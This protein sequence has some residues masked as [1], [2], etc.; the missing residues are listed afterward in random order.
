MATTPSP[1][2]PPPAAASQGAASP[3]PATPGPAN[4]E[5]ASPPPTSSP[6]RAPEPANVGVLEADDNV[7]A[8]D[9][10]SALGLPTDVSDTT[11]IASFLFKYREQHGRTYHAYRS[12][13]EYNSYWLPNDERE[14][15]RLDLQHNLFLMMQDNQL[16][17]CP[18]VK[19]KE[20]K[21]VLDAG[22]GTGV[23]AMDFAD[24][25]PNVSV[26]GTDISA[27]QPEFVPP[28]LEF[29][30]DD[31]EADWNFVNKFDFIYARF[32][33]GSIKDWPRFFQQSF[34]HLQPGGY[35]EVCDILYPMACD[36]GTLPDDSALQKWVR[37]V[38][39]GTRRIGAP[40]DS[41]LHYKQQLIDA[42]FQNV[43]EVKY[44]WPLNTWPK[45]KKHKEL[46]AWSLMN[47]QD[48]LSA[49]SLM[50]FTNVL[51]WSREETELLLM[52][53]RK[54]MKNTAYHGYWPIW[55]VYGQK[56]E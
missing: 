18:H 27:I 26:V 8:D 17:T 30:V 56:P 11:S 6:A 34:E 39:E 10:D 38:L 48:A 21:R 36:D 19:G 12:R 7:P 13:G 14:N 31:L 15:E 54:D 25:H 55:V 42:G 49:L 16:F 4:P 35:I 40:L 23:W 46:G 37:L 20:L 22:C 5:A 29:F 45:D 50:M 51:G 47:F 1:S 32:L 52:E 44:K 53:V 33:T 28:N 9:G 3:A 41:A 24:E 43:H 2:S